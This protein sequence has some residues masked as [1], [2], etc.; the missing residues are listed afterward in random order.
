MVAKA[1]PRQRLV[2]DG[3]NLATEGRTAPSLVQ[4][5]EVVRAYLEENPKTEVIV[6]ADATFEHRVAAAERSRF[7]EAELAGEIVTPPAGAVGRG[8]AFILKIAARID[9]VVLS[10]DSFQEFQE[11]HPWL[12]EQGR[13]VGGKPVPGV[14]WVFTDRLPV[15]GTKSP[16]AVKK[17]T[18]ALPDGARRWAFRASDTSRTCSTRSSLWTS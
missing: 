17:L 14:G 7:K 15:R 8:D 13:L 10:N 18:V 9:A 16:R 11:E 5:D 2:V 4:L 12:F 6:V 1:L 3:S